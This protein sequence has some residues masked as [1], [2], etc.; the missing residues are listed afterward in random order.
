MIL[1]LF[2]LKLLSRESYFGIVLSDEVV[3]RCPDFSFRYKPNA[4][5]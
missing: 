4:L 2:V 5:Y 3:L 1:Y